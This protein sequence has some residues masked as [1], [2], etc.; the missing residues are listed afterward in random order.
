VD[1]D[2]IERIRYLLELRPKAPG[3]LQN[4]MGWCVSKWV[5]QEWRRTPDYKLAE[6]LAD[7]I[8]PTDDGGDRPLVWVRV[9][10]RTWKTFGAN[11]PE[12]IEEAVGTA[13]H[14]YEEHGEF[15]DD[16]DSDLGPGPGSHPQGFGKTHHYR[17]LEWP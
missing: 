16:P 6:L 2:N 4:A 7:V 14:Y 8:P 12:G 11:V 5:Y 15:W 9:Q 10:A 17:P 13:C 3:W 1:R